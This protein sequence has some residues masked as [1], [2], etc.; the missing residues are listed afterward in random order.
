MEGMARN[1]LIVGPPR[2]GT[3]LAASI[4]ADAGYHLGEIDEPR[5]REGD[6]HNPFGY[7]EADAAI[8]RSVEVLHRTGFSHH[9]TWTSGAISPESAEAIRDLEPTDEH[10]AFVRRYREHEPWVWKDPRLC[11]TLPYWW[12]LMDADRTAV[13]LVTRDTDDVY[14]SFRRKE[15]CGPGEEERRDTIE[16]IERH[17]AAAERAVATLGAPHERV[18]YSD[19]SDDLP[20]VAR[21]LGETFRIDLTADDIPFRPELD[22]SDLRG[23]ISGYLRRQLKRLPRGPVERVADLIPRRLLALVFPERRHT[24]HSHPPRG[25]QPDD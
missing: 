4:F 21:R 11:Y 18:E 15:W 17:R 20:D 25:S 14:R 7:F 22:H 24:E 8:E 16:R 1:A 5:Y 6:D 9:N 2:T 23:R 10:R 3:S 19:Y 13:L 12:K